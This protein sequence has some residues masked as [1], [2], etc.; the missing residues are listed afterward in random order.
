LT[1]RQVRR[2]L[3]FAG[4]GRLQ[5]LSHDLD[6]SGRLD[7]KLHP[8]MPHRQHFDEYAFIDPEPLAQPSIE[9]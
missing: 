3:D 5:L 9:D 6:A 4:R 7:A 8:S 2:V 1:N